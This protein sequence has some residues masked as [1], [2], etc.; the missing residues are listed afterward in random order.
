MHYDLNQLGDPRRF[1]RLINSILTARF[2]ENARITPLHGT[3][4]GSD[5]ETAPDNPHLEYRYTRTQPPSHNPLIEPPIPG[6][7]LFQAKYHRTGDQRLSDLRATVVRE[8][9]NE[10]QKNVL[11]RPDRNDVNYFFLVTNIPASDDA[12]TRVDRVRTDLLHTPRRLHADVWWGERIT[13]LLDWAPHLWNEFSEIFPGAVP[14]LITFPDHNDHRKLLRTF[15]TA[16]SKQYNRD[17]TVKFRQGRLENA[18]LDLFVDLNV[19]LKLSTQSMFQS[20]WRRM[21]KTK[22]QS[23]GHLPGLFSNN[24]S[25]IAPKSALGIILND[26]VGENRILLEGGPG[27]GKSTITQ[28]AAQIYREKILNQYE[29][30]TRDQTW[31]EISRLRFPVRI[32]LK[33]FALWLSNNSDA[34]L[35]EFITT[36]FSRDAG[37]VSVTVDDLHEFL[38]S[39]SVIL[40]LDGLDEI[41]SDS[42]RDRVL[43]SVMDTIQRFQD[44]LNVDLRVVLTTRPPALTGRRM[45][46]TSFTQVLLAPMQRERIDDYVKRWL[47]TQVHAD[48]Q[49]DTIETRESIRNAFDERLTEPHVE[50]LARNPMQLSLLLHFISL[51]GQA[52]PDRRAEL[53]REYFE[54]VIDRDVE[55][56]LELRESREVVESLHSFLGFRLH[57]SAEGDEGRRTLKRDEIITLSESWLRRQGYDPELGCKFFSLGVERFGLIVAATGEGEKTNYGFEIQPIQEYF[58]ASFISDHLAHNGLEGV[59]SHQVFQ[60][61]L[62]RNYWREVCLFLAGLRRPN[63]RIDLVVRARIADNEVDQTWNHNGRTITL[64]L[65]REGVLA[66]PQHVLAEAVNFVVE[67]LDMPTLVLRPDPMYIVESICLLVRRYRH[68][69]P[70]DRILNFVYRYHNLPDV[71]GLLLVHRL[72][73]TLLSADQY[74]QL[75]LQCESADPRVLATARVTCPYESS[76]TFQ[77]LASA[78]GYFSGIPS[79]TLARALW[80]MALKSGV[81]LDIALPSQVHLDL[82]VQF[83]ISALDRAHEGFQV[84]T[85]QSFSSWSIWKL[86]QNLQVIGCVEFLNDDRFSDG[87]LTVRN[88]A[89]ISDQVLSDSRLSYDHLPPSVT[90]CMRDLIDSSSAIISSL[91]DKD[92]ANLESAIDRHLRAIDLHLEDFGVSGWV[93]CRCAIEVLH[94]SSAFLFRRHQQELYHNLLRRVIGYYESDC[95]PVLHRYYLHRAFFG[96]PSRIILPKDGRPAPIEKI[97]ADLVLGQAD[98]LDDEVLLCADGEVLSSLVIRPLVESCRDQIR[99]LLEHLG[100]RSI[101]MIPGTPRLKVQDTHRILKICRQEDEKQILRGASTILLNARFARI[102]EPELVLKILIASPSAQLVEHVLNPSWA[103]GEEHNS[104]ASIPEVDLADAVARTVLDAPESFPLEIVHRA[105]VFVAET[106]VTQNTSLFEEHPNLGLVIS[107]DLISLS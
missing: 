64:Q 9:K 71:L 88:L 98:S 78:P 57:G 4:G 92:N 67:V 59:F 70:T 83:S 49:V 47:E 90:R 62:Q 101:S 102:A 55:K 11:D 77:S 19:D 50:A 84:V 28:M 89:I 40:F 60:M 18:L 99:R 38:E 14:P 91:I 54:L 69:I 33:N 53:Y 63:E 37:N 10:L 97:L 79:Q 56:S 85:I 36:V 87:I 12:I 65:L 41:G 17:K 107:E 51:K 43:T 104:S 16:L 100:E 75:V 29:S 94:G 72:A 86:L 6:R 8:F 48:T 42:L 30:K 35:E 45:R 105:A 31:H 46:L 34:S 103:Y 58:A 5:G 20:S 39:S 44:G 73:R 61:L 76:N 93:A 7:Y 1:Q 74:K 27:H 2:G 25:I 15:R 3:D 24:R 81:V 22:Y 52:F 32:E 68:A 106:E 82:V 80:T 66:Q 95:R 96:I 21:Q 23:V 26:S 13:A